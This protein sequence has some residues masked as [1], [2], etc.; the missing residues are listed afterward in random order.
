MTADHTDPS[1]RWTPETWALIDQLTD[2]IAAGL[3]AGHPRRLAE[4]AV[5]AWITGQRPLE[6][7]VAQEVEAGDWDRPPLDRDLQGF[8]PPRL[9]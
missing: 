2:W 9:R 4:Y 1:G 5:S 8:R 3:A 7:C 6:A